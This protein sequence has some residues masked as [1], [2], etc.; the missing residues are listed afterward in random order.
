MVWRTKGE[1][2]FNREYTQPTIAHSPKINVWGCFD[3]ERVGSF[4][5][6]EGIM[7]KEVYLTVNI[8]QENM[9]ESAN[10]LF[11]DRNFYFQQD[12]D[13]KHTARVVK[14]WINAQEFNLLDWPS[15]SPDLNPIENVWA[16]MK[17]R[18]STMTFR[19]S[20]ELM[21]GLLQIWESLPRTFLHNLVESMPSRVKA[22]IANK[23]GSSGY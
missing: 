9:V 17:Q 11:H 18:A 14:E 23:G 1:S 6:I 3:N 13:P 15:Q 21:N 20:M 2:R 22:V 19:N 16:Y 10:N 8:L 7:T 12:N 5:R 4:I